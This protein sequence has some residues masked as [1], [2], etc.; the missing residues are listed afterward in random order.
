[1]IDDR[2][3]QSSSSSDEEALSFGGGAAPRRTQQPVFNNEASMKPDLPVKT[4]QKVQNVA[5]RAQTALATQP[6]E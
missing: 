3:G 6:L 5:E 4:A 1:M 2:I